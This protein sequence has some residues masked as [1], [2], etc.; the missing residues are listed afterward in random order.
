MRLHLRPAAAAIITMLLGLALHPAAFA[1]APQPKPAPKSATPKP[2]NDLKPAFDALKAGDYAKAESI[3]KP[4]AERK[5]MRAQFM[6]GA[7]VYGFEKSPLYDLAKAIPLLRDAA[8]RGFPRAMA[9]YGGALAAGAGVTQD[10][11][12]AY[13]YLAL[14][15]RQQIPGTEMLLSGLASEMTDDEVERAKKAA[16][17]F[18]PRR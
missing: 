14:A 4:M 12:E 8:E 10:K 6:L 11:V 13:K 7:E 18:A 2:T 15:S 17:T 9:A 16:D 3:L 1:Q 5:D